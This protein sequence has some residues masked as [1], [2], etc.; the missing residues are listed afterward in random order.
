ML[1]IWSDQVRAKISIQLK[2]GG[3]TSKW[4]YT[5]DPHEVWQFLI[6]FAKKNRENF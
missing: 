5:H 1:M 4:L 3:R 6:S 2:I